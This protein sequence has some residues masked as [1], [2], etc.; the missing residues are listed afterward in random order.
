MLDPLYVGDIITSTLHGSPFPDT[1]QA[2][3]LLL[4]TIAVETEF[5]DLP[6]RGAQPGMGYF[7]LTP[8]LEAAIWTDYLQYNVSLV[9]WFANHAGQFY[10]NPHALE[11]NL[12][13]SVLLARSLYYWRDLER[14]PDPEEIELQARHWRRYWRQSEDQGLEAAYVEAYKRLVLPH[15]P[16]HRVRKGG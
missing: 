13:Y 3:Y 15:Y 16:L 12:S 5:L 11:H 4:G 6:E 9:W 10:P 14:L 8:D 2:T 1:H 7:Q